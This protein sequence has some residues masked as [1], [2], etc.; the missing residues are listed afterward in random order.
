MMSILSASERRLDASKDPALATSF[1][2]ELS[3]GCDHL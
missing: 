2:A 1:T 3:T